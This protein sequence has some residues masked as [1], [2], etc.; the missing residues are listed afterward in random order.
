MLV[1]VCFW[2]CMFDASKLAQEFY[3]EGYFT[4]VVNGGVDG[5]C[6]D[7]FHAFWLWQ[8]R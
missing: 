5:V 2:C 1:G 4:K 7:T 6:L 3:G 8:A